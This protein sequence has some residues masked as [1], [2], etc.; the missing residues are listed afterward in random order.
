MQNKTVSK[1][2]TCNQLYY[3]FNKDKSKT[4]RYRKIRNL[5]LSRIRKCALM[6]HKGRTKSKKNMI[7]K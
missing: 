4:R 5:Y 3:R 6:L 7:D 2:L 1:R